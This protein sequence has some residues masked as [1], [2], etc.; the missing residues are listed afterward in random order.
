MPWPP[1][2]HTGRRAATP[3]ACDRWVLPDPQGLRRSPPGPLVVHRPRRALALLAPIAQPV[4]SASVLG[5]PSRAAA[6]PSRAAAGPSRSAVGP[7]RSA[8][9]SMRATGAP[10]QALGRPN[11]PACGSISGAG[12]SILSS[13]HLTSLRVVP[14]AE[15]S[16]AARVQP[17]V[18]SAPRPAPQPAV[19]PRRRAEVGS[20]APSSGSNPAFVGSKLPTG[21]SK[22]A[23]NPSRRR[24]CAISPRNGP[25]RPRSRVAR[26]NP[27]ASRRGASVARPMPRRESRARSRRPCPRSTPIAL[28][29]GRAEHFG[30]SWPGSALAEP[31]RPPTRSWNSS[32]PGLRRA[33]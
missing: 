2:A 5:P 1:G 17:W 32:T 22:L 11:F 12:G 23:S 6:R 25:S 4:S 33:E 28:R 29:R 15:P 27:R 3:A 14:W 7:S 18:R 16:P 13:T 30:R 8:A 31:T 19:A 20:N 24:A 10:N 26:R 9:G 21:G